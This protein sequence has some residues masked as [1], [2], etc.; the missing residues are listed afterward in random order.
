MAKETICGVNI[1]TEIMEMP[2][3]DI[4]RDVFILGKVSESCEKE[5][6]EASLSSVQADLCTMAILIEQRITNILLMAI[7]SKM[8]KP[9]DMVQRVIVSIDT[10]KQKREEG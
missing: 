5:G 6:K 3:K 9:E 2:W 4:L 8:L 7:A 1:E 10:D